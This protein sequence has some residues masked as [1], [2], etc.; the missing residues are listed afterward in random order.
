METW[1]EER[2]KQ[3]GPLSGDALDYVLGRGGK[4]ETILDLG[5]THWV[6]PSEPAPSEKFKLDYGSH[7]DRLRDSFVIPLRSPKG[8]LLGI[9]CQ[10]PDDR[11]MLRYLLPRGAWN[12]VWLGMS[13]KVMQQIWDGAEVWLVEGFFDLT[14][15]QW[16]LPEG[17]VVLGCLTAKLSD[18]QALFCQRFV[19][20]V[21]M[22]FDSDVAGRKG[23]HWAQIVLDRLGV[24]VRVIQYPPGDPGDLWKNGGEYA[25][26]RIFGPHLPVV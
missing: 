6:E 17:H 22:V 25:L 21:H 10:K 20:Q 24:L 11:W 1:L 14:A 9:Q 7:G 5:I 8:D 12:P 3:G 16:V 23:A 18:Q 19:K 26:Q 13:P 4:P 15:L 2:L